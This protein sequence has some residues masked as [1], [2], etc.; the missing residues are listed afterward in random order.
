MKKTLTATLAALMLAGALTA[1][2]GATS[3]DSSSPAIL[4]GDGSAPIPLA[5]A[6]ADANSDSPSL[7]T[8]F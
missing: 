1:V 8:K 5:L 7:S 6:P 2:S 3:V 4:I